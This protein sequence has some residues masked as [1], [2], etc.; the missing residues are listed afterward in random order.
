VTPRRAILLTARREVRERVRSRAFRVGLAIQVALVVGISLVA[1][2]TGGDGPKTVTIGVSGPQA[3][4][5]AAA[6]QDRSATFELDLERK[7]YPSPAA[8]RA[9]VR[10]DDVDLALAGTRLLVPA[11]PDDQAVALVRSAAATLG[12]TE[13]LRAQG[14]SADEIRD[15]LN[16][17]Q[18]A[19][20]EVKSG[21]EGGQ[22]LAFV[23]VLLLYI[24]LLTFGNVVAIGVIEE[25]SSR[26]IELIL[27]TVRA[28]ELLA[29][30]VLGIG[31]VGL[32]QLLVVG[33]SGLAVAVA[34]GELELPSSTAWTAV[35]VALYFVLGYLLYA[36]AYAMAG[37]L[38]SRQEDAQSTTTPMTVV[39]IG[40]YLLSLSVLDDPDSTLATITSFVP[41]LAP[42]I[43]PARAA[44]DAL[45]AWE[46]AV[47]V[48]LMLAS[49]A[50]LIRLAGRVYE[51]AVL[52]MGAPLKLS[53]AL[54]L[55]RAR[56]TAPR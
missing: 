36:C 47:S 46:L 14:L 43:V 30:K 28:R 40:G 25:K 17:P 19:T 4:A 10:D 1:A 7:P 48:L 50:L 45:P 15:A 54:R 23:G 51:R 12:T 44:Q 41:P 55:A 42:M 5:V 22:G 31:L 38:V 3:A 6:A 13:R 37:A 16:P 53:Q 2:L 29:G 26:V 52:R 33:G 35:L 39:L 18:L 11:D 34:T 21:D 27:S 24:A 32:V 20:V 49:S 9:A 56:E 8:A